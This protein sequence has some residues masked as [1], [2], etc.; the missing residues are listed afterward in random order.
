MVIVDFDGNTVE[1]NFVHLLIQKHMQCLY[2]HWE[3]I[4][5]I[6]TYTF[7]LCYRMGTSTTGYSYLWNYAC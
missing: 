6:A 2:K 3:K 7:Y 4:G 1:G 5:G